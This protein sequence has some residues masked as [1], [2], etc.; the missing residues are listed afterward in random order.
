MFKECEFAAI[1]SKDPQK[2]L[3]YIPLSRNLQGAIKE[4]WESQY[5]S[6][7]NG[8]ERIINFDPDYKL[9]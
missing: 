1:I 3:R 5:N 6:F 9:D 7:F 4:E 8:K 2:E